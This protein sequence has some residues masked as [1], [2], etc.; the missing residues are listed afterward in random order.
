MNLELEGSPI[1]LIQT[2]PKQKKNDILSVG[3]ADNNIEE[4]KCNPKQTLQQL[5]D[6]SKERTILYVTGASGSGKSYYVKNFAD[7]Y[8]KLYPK[9]PIYV[10]SA[11]ADD[12]GSLDK[13]K[14][15]QRV[16]IH[17]PEFLAEQI[18]T[19]EF[20]ESL[21]IFDDCEAIGNKTLRKKVWEIQNGILTTGRHHSISCAVCTHTA[22]NGNET[23]LILNE[24]HSVTIFPTGLGG[25]SLKYLLE[26]YFGLDKN[27]IRK[28]KKLDSRWVTVVKGY[29]MTVL[30]EKEAYVLRNTDD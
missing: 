3:K 24:A 9:R 11:L 30:S 27:Q 14:K 28:L 10:F 22:T 15:L 23:K 2:E 19:D 7:Q 21:C 20:K 16:K 25:R 29:P 12:T 5:P 18:S 8:R 17:D 1:A 4:F 6:V 13:I 26:G